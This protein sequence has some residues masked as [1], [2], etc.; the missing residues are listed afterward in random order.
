MVQGET[1]C[2]GCQPT[3]RCLHD[4]QIVS[5][6][7]WCGAQSVRLPDA[8]QCLMHCELSGADALPVFEAKVLLQQIQLNPS[9]LFAMQAKFRR[10][11]NAKDVP[12]SL[13]RSPTSRPNL[14]ISARSCSNVASTVLNVSPP[15]SDYPGRL[16]QTTPRWSA[17]SGGDVSWLAS[18]KHHHVAQ[19]PMAVETDHKEPSF[20]HVQVI[21]R[22]GV[23]HRMCG[24]VPRR[25]QNTLP[26][27]VPVRSPRG[28]AGRGCRPSCSRAPAGTVPC[29][30]PARAVGP[31]ARSAGDRT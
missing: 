28:P 1:A 25:S 17:S 14:W 6:A 27:R 15:I 4:D 22:E 8:F 3:I 5:S 9:S 23:T 31:G 24:F 2:T 18:P 7:A 12:F 19:Q 26:R 11:S 10:R 13:G 29:A 21:F 20:H 16:S 30:R